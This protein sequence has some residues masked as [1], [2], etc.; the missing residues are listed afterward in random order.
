M[1]GSTQRFR[2]TEQHWALWI[3]L[4]RCTTTLHVTFE[5]T[6]HLDPNAT[7]N[8]LSA[9]LAIR[10]LNFLG[11]PGQI[12]RELTSPAA[13]AL[14][15]LNKSLRVEPR[16]SRI[17]MSVVLRKVSLHLHRP[18][19]LEQSDGIARMINIL[20]LPSIGHL[21]R[22]ICKCPITLQ[23]IARLI[24][25]RNHARDYGNGFLRF[26]I[27]DNPVK[28]LAE[29]VH[30]LVDFSLCEDYDDLAANSGQSF[31]IF[32]IGGGIDWPI[33]TRT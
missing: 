28:V 27:G 22:M 7:L 29:S 20:D 24:N 33:S 16:T 12:P 5:Q 8:L 30:S 17:S 32:H 10:N 13:V 14:H 25:A 31:S 23:R 6:H 1:L 4:F 15:S 9:R 3:L 19:T 11:R 21:L 2:D 18:K 26:D